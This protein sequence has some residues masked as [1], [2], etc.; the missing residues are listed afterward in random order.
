MTNQNNHNVWIWQPLLAVE[1]FGVEH[2]PWDYG[3]DFH[4]EGNEI[5]VAFQPLPVA[6]IIASVKAAHDEPDKVPSK[7]EA[8]QEP[9]PTF[10]PHPNTQAADLF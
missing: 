6:D 4:Q 3:V 9:H 1:I 2:L 8:C 7:E 5:E 10:P